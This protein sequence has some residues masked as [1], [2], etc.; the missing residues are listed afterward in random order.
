METFNPT[1]DDRDV[2][3]LI[4]EDEKVSRKA[5]ARLLARSGYTAEAFGSAE[6]ALCMLSS[7]PAP[8]VALVDLD[9][10]G[11]SGAE[12]LKYLSQIAPLA[13]SV[14]ISAASE[15][16]LLQLTSEKNIRYLRKPIDFK[17][18]LRDLDENLRPN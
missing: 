4:I 6:E 18:L 12:F 8:R 10:P 14:L 11:M 15:E 7:G 1:I 9:L 13:H 3:I 2:L 16:R 17:D 5:L